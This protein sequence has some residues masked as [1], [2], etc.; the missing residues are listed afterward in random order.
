MLTA[1]VTL[2]NLM[3]EWSQDT[4]IDVN[5][6]QKELLKISH[7]HGKYLNIMSFHRVML[8]K[9]ET[10]YKVMRGLR[11]EYYHGRLTKED[12]DANGWEQWQTRL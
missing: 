5:D 2:E 10:D 11:E 6:I 12:L 7:L 3:K 1:P 8:R 4:V 9:M